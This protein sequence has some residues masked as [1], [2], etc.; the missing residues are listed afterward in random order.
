MDTRAIVGARFIA[1][2]QGIGLN[3]GKASYSHLG[4]MNHA[5]TIV[6]STYRKSSY[7]KTSHRILSVRRERFPLK[8]QSREATLKRFEQRLGALSNEGS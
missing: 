5:P 2:H 6:R 8:V 4:V 3:I 1:P 7:K